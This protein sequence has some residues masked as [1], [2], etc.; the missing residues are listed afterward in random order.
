MPN[1]DWRECLTEILDAANQIDIYTQDMSFNEFSED[2]RTFDAVVRNFIVIG[3]AARQVSPDVRPRFADIP[4]GDMRD[5]RNALIHE[6]FRLQK[7][8]IWDTLIYDL[9]NLTP[10]VR[11][12]L[13]SPQTP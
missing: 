10:L 11:D 4:W 1:R 12:A 5:M 3:E 13:Q 8:R 7:L 6:Y 2:R 9:P